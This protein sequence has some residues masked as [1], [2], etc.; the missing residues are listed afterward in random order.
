MVVFYKLARARNGAL[1]GLEPSPT[2][3]TGWAGLQGRNGRGAGTLFGLASSTADTFQVTAKLDSLTEMRRKAAV[4]K[5]ATQGFVLRLAVM[6][7]HVPAADAF[8]AIQKPNLVSHL[9]HEQPE[10]G[11]GAT[12]KVRKASRNP[13]RS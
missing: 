10:F 2:D 8:Q 11:R 13:S 12:Q 6:K 1:A 9:V 7:A 5:R 3:P 4:K